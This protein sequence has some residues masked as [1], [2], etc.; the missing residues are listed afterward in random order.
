MGK[1]LIKRFDF[2]LF[3][4]TPIIISG[5]EKVF[6]NFNPVMSQTSFLHKNHQR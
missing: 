1:N 6:Q 2:D 4:V 3:L 5:F